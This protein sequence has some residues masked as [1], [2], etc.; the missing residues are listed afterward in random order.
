LALALRA[1]ARGTGASRTGIQPCPLRKW[2]ISQI[3]LNSGGSTSTSYDNPDHAPIAGGRAGRFYFAPLDEQ[4]RVAWTL[5]NPANATTLTLELYQ[6]GNPA[7]IWTRVLNADQARAQRLAAD[8]DGS[9]PGGEW[10]GFPD[11]LVTVEHSPYKLKAT[12]GA[13]R[14]DDYEVR[15]TYFDVII[16]RIELTWGG[17][18]LVPGG[19]RGDIAALYQAQTL[20]DEQAINNQLGL[21]RQADL[22]L[23]PADNYD[24]RLRCNQFTDWV[25]NM[26]DG[27]EARRSTLWLKH[28]L[29]WGDG[30]RIP[31]VAKVYIA[32]AAGGGVHGAPSARAL[33]GTKFMW[34]WESQDEI[35]ALPGGHNAAVAA[36]LT[37]SLDY[38][39]NDPNGPPGSTNCHVE[40]GGKRGAGAAVFGRLA[41]V[42]A[43]TTACVTRTWAT[44][45]QA[46]LAGPQAGCVGVVFQPSRIGGDTYRVVVHA[47]PDKCCGGPAVLDVATAGATL[48][49]NFPTLPT[50]RSG[51]FKMWR[52]VR[53]R[54]VRK[55]AA[56][57]TA[58]RAAIGTEYRRADLIAD[59]GSALD[60]ATDEATLAANFDAWCAHALAHP[61]AKGNP[62]ITPN[63][64]R[65]EAPDQFQAGTGGNTSFG[66]VVES[67]ESITRPTLINSIRQ[68]VMKNRTF[69]SVRNNYN[70]WLNGVGHGVANDHLYLLPFYNGLSAAKKQKV[71]VIFDANLIAANLP[72][73][74]TYESDLEGACIQVARLVAEQLL[75]QINEHCMIVFH[76][77]APV[78]YR[79]PDATIVVPP[80]GAGGLSPSTS[81][82]FNGRGSVNLVFLPEV[83]VADPAAKYHV[84]VT[85]VVMHEAAHNLYLCHAPADPA[86]TAAP[87]ARQDVHDLADLRCLM[88]YDQRSDHL[89][90]YCHLKLRGWG[91]IA[92]RNLLTTVGPIDGGLVKLWHDAARNQ[93]P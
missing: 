43:A 81:A 41:P 16:D 78:G 92:S 55:S 26:E 65:F 89:C 83:P 76:V 62:A 27:Q 74:A 9:F 39:R 66:F 18:A 64:A 82:K 21:M 5:V 10:I 59:W 57:A 11:H 45:E 40:H 25:W 30:P 36:F 88:N 71:Q 58:D 84:P 32:R 51:I 75:V 72:T 4:V 15:W 34:D 77:E 46:M 23:N 8:W 52:E 31:L 29:Q 73:K 60:R 6:W 33:G 12:A 80:S 48:R 35:A 79:Q 49:G 67:W 50:A 63:R 7:P 14:E 53:I 91:T 38:K 2:G 69:N 68:Y 20:A 90:G 28:Q 37:R 54:Y 93:V 1:A 85:G 87:G 42:S 13:N 44:F 3:T 17:A 47:P 22:T 24:V 56:V 61:D 70:A 19:A 86:L